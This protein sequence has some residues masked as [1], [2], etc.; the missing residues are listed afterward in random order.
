MVS[1]QERIVERNSTRDLTAPT[2]ESLDPKNRTADILANSQDD[3]TAASDRKKQQNQGMAELETTVLHQNRKVVR[4]NLF[5][6][7]HA[8]TEVG[9]GRPRKG[10]GELSTFVQLVGHA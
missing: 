2:K 7:Q 1:V 9:R 3:A 8:H 6:V 5:Q 10:N 4:L